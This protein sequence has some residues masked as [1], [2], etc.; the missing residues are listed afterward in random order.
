[1]QVA[2]TSDRH[3]RWWSLEVKF[4][5]QQQLGAPIGDSTLLPAI[6]LG[7]RARVPDACGN[8]PPRNSMIA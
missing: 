2:Q 5:P 3:R 1:M 7:G 6:T 8:P 4:K